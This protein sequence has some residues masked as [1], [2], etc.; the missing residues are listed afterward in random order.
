MGIFV[1]CDN[2]AFK[3][4]LNSEIYIDK[5]GLLEYTNKVM[6]TLQGYI[7]NSRPRR[8]GKS[9]TANM[10][11][12]YYSRGCDSEQIFADLYISQ[13]ADYKKHL[14]KYD[15]IHFDIQWCIE[16]AGG[17]ENVISYITEK[18]I[19]ELREYYPEQ[20]CS[21][22]TSLPEALSLINA[23]TG[24]KFV[25]IID[26]W[27]VLIRDE[28]NNKKI[29]DDYI[30]FLRAMFKGT[31]PTKYIQLAYLTGILPIKKLKTQ[32]ALNNFKQYSM[33]A[34]GAIS[35]YVGFTEDE[36]RVLCEKYGQSFDEVKRW[37]DGYLL[38]GT[39]IYNPKAVVSVMTWGDFQSYWSKTGTYES[40]VP[41]IN[42]N[43]DGLK[44]AII[45]MLSGANVKVDTATFKNDTVNI[46]S[47]DDVLT[48][49]IHLG[50]LGYDQYTKTAFIPNEEIRQEL[51]VAVESRSWNEMLMFQQESE[52]LLDATLDMD[53]VMV[54]TQI[55]KIHNEYISVI[56]YHN[57]NSLSSV[58]TIAY[59][60]AMQYYFKPI[61]ELP[62]GRGFA[63]FVYIPKP[64]YKADYPALIVEL[65]WNQN[66]Q[67]AMQ[68]IKNKKYPTA[69]EN[70]RGDIL[71]VGIS[72]DKNCKEHQCLI[73][74]YEKES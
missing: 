32:S 26:E 62:T 66:A 22:V 15:V 17:P 39:Q 73:E 55:E 30:N 34:S 69:I 11:T 16:P 2:S 58:L 52:R 33:L 4:A 1:N 21:N 3:V 64:E 72:Y 45:E 37:Y 13:S 35:Q 54:G 27:D 51:T 29:Q 9:I 42:M 63:D 60:S 14:N 38:S 57:E 67:T 5:T 71:L 19:E 6:N 8:F 48:Y 49:M 28:A 50:Y 23:A 53:G 12:A 7:C 18:T 43:F 47:K 36:V 41:L 24:R 31:E 44:T 65:K 61:R 74:K 10:L 40:I 46:H 59:L 56:Q 25:V 20:L 70:Y 68:Q